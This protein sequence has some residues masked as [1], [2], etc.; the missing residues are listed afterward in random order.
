MWDGCTMCVVPRPGR[1]TPLHPIT[2]ELPWEGKHCPVPCKGIFGWK[3]YVLRAM[4]TRSL[5]YCACL[6]RKLT[7]EWAIFVA[8]IQKAHFESIF[9]V[10]ALAGRTCREVMATCTQ[11]QVAFRGFRGMEHFWPPCAAEAVSCLAHVMVRTT[12]CTF[13]PICVLLFLTIHCFPSLPSVQSWIF[14]R[15]GLPGCTSSDFY[16]FLCVTK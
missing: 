15:A 3:Q 11:I 6:E 14:M 7:G 5:V 9:V 13:D 1:L 12:L 2:A 4:I 8:T 16:Q 10:S